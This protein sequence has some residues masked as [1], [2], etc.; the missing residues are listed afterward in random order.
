MKEK[1]SI[2]PIDAKAEMANA[3]VDAWYYPEE[4]VLTVVVEV[5]K[6]NRYVGTAVVTIPKTKLSKWAATT[7]AK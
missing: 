7:E 4:T 3:D 2:K 6:N 1:E 5:K